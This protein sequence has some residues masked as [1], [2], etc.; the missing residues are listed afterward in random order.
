MALNPFMNLFPGL[1]AKPSKPVASETDPW[2]FI[3]QMMQGQQDSAP[4]PTGPDPNLMEKLL[5]NP[6]VVGKHNAGSNLPSYAKGYTGPF[7]GDGGF[8]P[9]D[10]AFPELAK[11]PTA[12]PGNAQN[13]VLGAA[14][15]AVNQATNPWLGLLGMLQQPKQRV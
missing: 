8:K 11:P 9:M 14:G 5:G 15:M 3:Q 7:R 6:D 13:P 1:F 12:N 2:T 4:Q 10:Q